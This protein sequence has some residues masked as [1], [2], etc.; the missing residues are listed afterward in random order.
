MQYRV[1]KQKE[2][3]EENQYKIITDRDRNQQRKAHWSTRCIFLYVW[4]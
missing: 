4:P 1:P 2:I 3:A